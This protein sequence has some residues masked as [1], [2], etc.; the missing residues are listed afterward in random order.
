MKKVAI[1][2]AT[3]F[4]EIEA[5]TVIDV[6][7]R[8][9][10]Q[11]MVVSVTGRLEVTGSHHI[12]VMADL[13]F[14]D[15]G[16][17]DVDMMVLPGGMPGAVNLDSHEGLRQRILAFFNE[18]K[19]LAAICAG[20]MVYGNLGILENRNATCYPGFAKY[21]RNARIKDERVVEDQQFITANGPGSAMAFSL[22]LVAKLSGDETADLTGRKMLVPGI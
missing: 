18:G 13:L 8:S 3:G 4:E 22:R 16:F 11:V 20:P 7:R 14:E 17:S 2:L 5:V 21:L 12:R 10:V 9:E 15:A 6:L 1:M 19:F